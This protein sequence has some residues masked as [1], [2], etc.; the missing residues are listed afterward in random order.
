MV[1]ISNIFVD[2]SV[3]RL[4]LIWFDIS[5]AKGLAFLCGTFFSYY[6]NRKWT[7]SCARPGLLQFG[8]F[9]SVYGVVLLINVAANATALSTFAPDLHLRV[10]WA[11]LIATVL[12]A[13]LNFLGM[14][15][16][17]FQRKILK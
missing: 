15:F 8:K 16:F 12:S 14:K 4:L 9:L 17:V 6:F 1:G 11:Y 10:M 3:Y 2:Y 13:L 7:F 5:F